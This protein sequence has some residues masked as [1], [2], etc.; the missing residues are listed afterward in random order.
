MNQVVANKMLANKKRKGFTLV[1]LIVV[2]VV[3]AI[4]A[5][6]AIPRIVSFQDSARKARIQAEHRE[7]VTAIQLY[8]AANPDATTNAVSWANIAAYMNTNGK[9]ATADGVQATLAKNGDAVA[10]V[11]DD[12]KKTLTSTFTP[13]D[14][15]AATTWVYE[16][17]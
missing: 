13:S 4:I 5:A 1:E 9:G 17:K 7:L 3:I 6:I 14:N 11:L 8:R 12:A 16:Y 15:T 10:H 2:I